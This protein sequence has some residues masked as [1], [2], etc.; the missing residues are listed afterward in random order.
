MSLCTLTCVSMRVNVNS[1]ICMYENVQPIST[2]ILHVLRLKA[3]YE[4]SP[5]CKSLFAETWQKRPTKELCKMSLEVLHSS[6]MSLEVFAQ[7][8]KMSLEVFAKCHWRC[9]HFAQLFAKLE[10]IARRS[11]LPRFSEKRLTGWRSLI[12]CLLSQAIFRK[13]ATNYRAVLRR[14]TYTHK[15]SY[16]CSPPC[17]SFGFEIWFRFSNCRSLFPRFSE[18]RRTNFGFEIW[19]LVSENVAAGGIGAIYLQINK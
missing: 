12:G 1:R 19:F 15:A 16:G 6:P 17:T 7:L 13:R 2:D 5:P 10:A 11:L 14:M 8:C 4:S 9:A 18:K 3:S